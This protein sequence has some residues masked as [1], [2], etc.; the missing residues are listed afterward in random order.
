MPRYLLLDSSMEAEA[1]GSSKAGEVVAY[2]REVLRA[3]GVPAQEPTVIMTDNQANLQVATDSAS[4]SR[5][6]HFLRRY[7]ALQQ[8]LARGEAVLVKIDDD[9]MPADF[10]TKWLPSPKVRRSVE[11]ATNSR[12]IA[13]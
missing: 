10:L 12:A 7:Y 1:I 9:N 5:S 8:R 3:L 13:H 11:Y 6:R 2:A 4:A